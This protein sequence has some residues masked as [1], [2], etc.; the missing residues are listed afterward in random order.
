MG[1]TDVEEDMETWPNKMHNG[2]R[3]VVT[4]L[5]AMVKLHLSSKTRR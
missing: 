5:K 4:R 3:L 2:W 1:K